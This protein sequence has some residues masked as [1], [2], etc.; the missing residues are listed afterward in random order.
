MINS[1]K[2]FDILLDDDVISSSTAS[3][4]PPNC[5]VMMTV[6]DE[7]LLVL[8]RQRQ[9]FRGLAAVDHRPV[10]ERLQNNHRHIRNNA[11]WYD[12]RLNNMLNHMFFDRVFSFVISLH[13]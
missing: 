8:Q 6:H 12:V 2:S 10:P 3:R 11:C 4:C 1:H 13:K 5:H 9:Q 7:S